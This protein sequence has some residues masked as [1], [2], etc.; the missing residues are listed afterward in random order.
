MPGY[1]RLAG[2]VVKTQMMMEII[3]DDGRRVRIPGNAPSGSDIELYCTDIQSGKIFGYDGY[4]VTRNAKKL[5]AAQADALSAV[6][7][8]TM[9]RLPL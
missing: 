5:L 1:Q 6:R 9:E 8:P 2:T 4:E 3:L 7:P